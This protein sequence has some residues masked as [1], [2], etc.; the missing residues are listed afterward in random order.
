M[1][2]LTPWLLREQL[3]WTPEVGFGELVRE[4]MREDLKDAE[5]DRLRAR[6]VRDLEPQ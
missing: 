4:M 1:G 5:R 3:G 2:D 6:R